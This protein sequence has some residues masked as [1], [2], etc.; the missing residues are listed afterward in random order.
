MKL[1][2]DKNILFIKI[3]FLLNFLFHYSCNDAS[4]EEINN[5]ALSEYTN[6]TLL[7]S[8]TISIIGVGDIMMGSNYPSN[9]LPPDDGKYIFDAV[10]HI[11]SDADYTIG[12]LEG[13]LL[14]SGGIPKVCKRCVS[15]RTPVHYARYLKDAGF[16]AMNLANNHSNDMGPAGK[17]STKETLRNNG[18]LFFGLNEYPSDTLYYKNLKIGLIGFARN[19]HLNSPVVAAKMVEELKKSADIVIVSVHSG[20]EGLSALRV[21]KREEYYGDELRGDIYRFSHK[22]IDAGADL[23]LGHGP[24]VPRAIELYKNRLIVYSLGNFCTYAKFP[25]NGAQGYAPIIKLF[26]NGKGEFL[27]GKIISAKQIKG[28][29]PVPDKKNSAAILMRNLSLKDFPENEI[30][31]TEEGKIVFK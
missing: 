20:S 26:I 4:Q 10:K 2:A 24:H 28:G 1:S 19:H 8:D 14:N 31:I 12:N 7:F 15:F 22:L 23:I 5:D 17:K 11:L 16:D 30:E 29:I 3:L 21:P 25:L 9:V 13:T 27:K 6:D 18:I